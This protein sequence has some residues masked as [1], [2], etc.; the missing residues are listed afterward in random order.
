MARLDALQPLLA[1]QTEAR[2][3]ERSKQ[4][5]VTK[6][7][8]ERMVAEA[9]TLALGNDW[10][11]G[12]NRFRALLDEWKALPRIDRASDDALWH[13]FSAA[14]TTYTRRRKSQFAEQAAKRDVAQGRPRS[15]SSP[16]LASWRTPPSGDRRPARSAT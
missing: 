9:E 8:K 7:T 3:A 13:R 16:R 5:E 11:G 12:V 6:E 14:R 1:E 10:R 2:K 15:R 4:L